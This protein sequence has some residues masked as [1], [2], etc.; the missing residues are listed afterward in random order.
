MRRVHDAGVCRVPT[1]RDASC[2]PDVF[3]SQRLLSASLGVVWQQRLCTGGAVHLE[4][5]GGL[6]AGARTWAGE[7]SWGTKVLAGG[8]EGGP[9]PQRT[10]PCTPAKAAA[11]GISRDEGARRQLRRGV[12]RGTRR[13]G[14][15]WGQCHS[16]IRPCMQ[17]MGIEMPCWGLPH[18]GWTSEGVGRHAWAQPRS[19]R[20]RRAWCE[21]AE[22]RCAGTR[23]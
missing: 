22:C 11:T 21:V 12:G 15:E 10:R 7:G 14:D 13:G 3:S 23:G 5:G 1:L 8:A 19:C 6:R 16:A 9:D 17:P 20:V 18:G 2:P 4:G